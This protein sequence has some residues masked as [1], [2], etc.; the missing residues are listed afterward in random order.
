MFVNKKEEFAYRQT[1]VHNPNVEHEVEHEGFLVG[2][3]HKTINLSQIK[4][5]EL[6]EK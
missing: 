5:I 4:V 3:R 1:Y 2:S 6:I